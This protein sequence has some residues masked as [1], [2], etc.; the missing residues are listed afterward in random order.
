M[1]PVDLVIHKGLPPEFADQAG[2]ILQEA[3]S[4][5]LAV[6]ISRPEKAA[7]VVAKSLDPEMCFCAISKDQLLGIAGM[8]FEGKRFLNARWKPCRS[9]LGFFPGLYAFL[10]LHLFYGNQRPSEIYI[11]VVAVKPEWRGNGIGAQMLEAIAAYGRGSGMDALS[12]DVV[13][14]N[15]AAYRLYERLGYVPVK[16]IHYHIPE[17]LAGFTGSTIMRKPL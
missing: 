3:F 13:D 11:D 2:S 16:E 17:R 7:A 6:I 9:I 12:L 4:K 10:L 15:V 5:K 1:P 8:Q 14:T